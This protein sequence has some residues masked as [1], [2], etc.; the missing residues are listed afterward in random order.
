MFHLKKNIDISELIFQKEEVASA[1]YFTVEEIKK[2]LKDKTIRKSS[3]SIIL[4]YL[5]TNKD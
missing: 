2:S 4:D 3:R 1:K 5:I